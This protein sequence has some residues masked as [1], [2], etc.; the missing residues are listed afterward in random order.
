M[1]AYDMNV[2]N[3]D[4]FVCKCEGELGDSAHSSVLFCTT[5]GILLPTTF[6][7]LKMNVNDLKRLA[8]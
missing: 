5:S 4:N 7:E 6:S 1:I 2:I 8:Y 3:Q